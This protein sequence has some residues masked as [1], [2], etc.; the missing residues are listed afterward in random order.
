MSVERLALIG[1]NSCLDFTNTAGDHLAEHPHECLAN[2]HD[3]IIWARRAGILTTEQA[4]HLS[5]HATEHP[6][7]AQITLSNAIIFREIIYR[8]FLCAIRYQTPQ[9]SDVATFNQFLAEAPARIGIIYGDEKYTWKLDGEVDPLNYVLSHLVWSAAD[10]LASDQLHQVKICEGDDCG[11]LFLD[12]SRNQ[13]R[14]WC[15]M[16]DC[17]NRAKANRYYKRHKS[18]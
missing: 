10:L 4:D 1:G 16:A 9:T 17:G 14:R 2:P 8:L 18:E 7:I 11:W 13:S 12:T 6:E 5:R 15:S 3:L